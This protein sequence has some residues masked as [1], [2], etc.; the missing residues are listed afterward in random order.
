M[1][2]VQ[3]EYFEAISMVTDCA[4]GGSGILHHSLGFWRVT[5]SKCRRRKFG[6]GPRDAALKW[7]HKVNE[8]RSYRFNRYTEEEYLGRQFG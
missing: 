6:D 5:C 7:N 3:K 4:C 1:N 8:Q 2:R